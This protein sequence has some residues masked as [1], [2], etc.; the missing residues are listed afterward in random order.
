MINYAATGGNF[1]NGATNDG[2]LLRGS[3]NGGDTFLVQ[4]TLSGSTT[5]IVGN[6]GAD[7]FRIGSTPAD[8]NGDLDGIAGFLTIV[9]GNPA[10][11]AAP[12][13][14]NV[15]PTGQVDLLYVNDRGDGGK[16]NYRIGDFTNDSVDNPLVQDDNDPATPARAFAGVAYDSTMEYVRL[17]GTD[18]VNIFDI[19]PSL[20]TQYFIDGNLP[21]PGECIKGGG[22]FLRLDTTGTT[23]RKLHLTAVGEGFWSFTSGHR[24]VGF[25]SIERFNHVDIFATAPDSGTSSV[26]SDKVYDAETGE[27]LFQVFPFENS[28]KGGVRVATGDLNCDGLPDLIVAPGPGRDPLVKIYNGAPDA[29][30][31]HPASLL[32]SFSVFPTTFKGGVNLAVGDVNA[33]GHNDLLVAS[34]TGGPPALRVL[35]GEFLLTTHVALGPPFN[36]S[37][38]FNGGANITLGDINNDGYADIVAVSGSGQS[39]T[40]SVF[41]GNGFALV[42]SFQPF[43]PGVAGSMSSVAVGDFDGDGLRD[44]IVATGQ[45]SIGTVNVYRG[46]ANFAVWPV[47]LITSFRPY[48]DEFR[49]GVRITVKP[50]N[51]G[52]SGSVEKVN[53]L[54]APGVG[55][56]NLPNV[57]RQASFTGYAS[58]PALVDKLFE[59]PNFNA[60]FIG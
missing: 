53:I 51:G 48:G 10:A 13:A 55:G 35:D 34:D 50:A 21:P 56:G 7:T 60:I 43:G 29:D 39:M 33:D 49:G 54:T 46:A 11:P 58:P 4:S 3:N 22:D 41:S 8:N 12:F 14:T 52:N 15:D 28:F 19:R 36:A 2:V 26:V 16:R 20:T 40:V 1:N 59:D 27:L 18:D 57:I 17:D 45:G 38:T 23:G 30:G 32:T 47:T 44:I 9:G 37:P 42:K 24:P 6:D 25:E 5:K 31:N